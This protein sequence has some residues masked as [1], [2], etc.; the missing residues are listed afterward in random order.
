MKTTTMAIT[1]AAAMGFLAIAASKAVSKDF[2]VAGQTLSIGAET[3]L[4]YTTGVEDWVWELTP[5]AGVTALGI[6]LSVATDIDMLTLDEGDIFQGLD[7]TAD[8]TVPSTN[9]SLYTEVSTDSDLEFG[10]VTVGATVSF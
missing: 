9:I 4:N 5:S 3:D 1:I 6:G 2:S 10:D 8:Y 7:F